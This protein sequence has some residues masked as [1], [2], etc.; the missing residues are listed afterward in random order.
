MS[1]FQKKCLICYKIGEEELLQACDCSSRVH[2][3]C[4][5]SH[6]QCLKSSHCAFCGKEY[7]IIVMCNALKKCSSPV[8]EQANWIVLCVCVSTLLC[9][10]CMLLDICL[11]IR[12]WQSS[13]LGYEVYNT[14]Y[15]LVLC[16]TFSITFYLAAW[17]DT[18]FE[19]KSL[20]SFIWNLKKISQSYP[21]EASKNALKIL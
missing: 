20:C 3:T 5:Q 14:F 1:S 16:G 12:L 11:T 6:I 9:I 13:V 17:Y 15:L 21:C 10:L 2:H 8:L 19:F 4:L 18:F 7:K